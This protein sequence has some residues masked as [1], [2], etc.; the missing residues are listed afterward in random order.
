MICLLFALASLVAAASG[1]VAPTP[2]SACQETPPEGGCSVC[3]TGSCIVNQDAIFTFPG[4]PSV[5]CGMLQDAGFNGLIP[6][7]RCAFLPPLIGDLCECQPDGL[8]VAP[9]TPAPVAP[10][11][12]TAPGFCREITPEGGCSICGPGSCISNQDATLTVPG[13]APIPC[14]VLQDRGYNGQIPLYNCVDLVY[15]IGDLCQCA[16]FGPPPPPAPAPTTRAPIAPTPPSACQENPPE[17]GCSVCGTGSCITNQD[18]IFTILGMPSVTCS[19][20]QDGGYNGQIPLE[21]CLLLPPDV[22][23]ICECRSVGPD[24]VPTAPTGA[25]EPL[26]PP[27]SDKKGKKGSKKTSKIRRR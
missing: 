9:I 14:G 20:L 23:A 6:L 12:P 2:P 5:S 10:I 27:P 1:Q 7:N 17:G 8:S 26:T 4:Q 13:Q 3:G 24:I 19:T 22:A 15:L 11:V 25:R 21:I 16:R 18:A